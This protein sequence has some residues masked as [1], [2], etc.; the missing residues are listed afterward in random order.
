[1]TEV[2]ALYRRLIAAA[3]CAW[4][5]RGET[6]YGGKWA[7]LARRGPCAA[8]RPEWQL[9]AMAINFKKWCCFVVYILVPVVTLTVPTY[10]L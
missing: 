2:R 10:E 5:A 8:S 7:W 9:G 4:S 3:G 6:R 1:V